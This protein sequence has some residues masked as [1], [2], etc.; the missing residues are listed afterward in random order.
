M[1]VAFDST[2][3]DEYLVVALPEIS[4]EFPDDELTKDL[5]TYPVSILTKLLPPVGGGA[6]TIG[7]CCCCPPFQVFT[8]TGGA[9]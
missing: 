5:I 7:I 8:G 6:G 3:E 9:G 4:K 2:L 1:V